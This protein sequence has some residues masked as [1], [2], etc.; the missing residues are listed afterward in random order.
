MADTETLL[1][2]LPCPMAWLEPNGQLLGCNPAFT[3]L[4]TDA[5]RFFGSGI[6]SH[7]LEKCQSSHFWREALPG[8]GLV[9]VYVSHL[10]D[11]TAVLFYMQP[12]VD[13]HGSVLD[14]LAHP[15]FIQ[16]PDGSLLASNN[17]FAAF[18]DSER[19][20]LVGLTP[21]QLFEQQWHQ[22]LDQGREQLL[23]T[24]QL[25]PLKVSDPQG[26]LWWVQ[27]RLVLQQEQPLAIISEMWDITRQLQMEAELSGGQQ[28]KLTDQLSRE[29]FLAQLDDQI[30][31][32]NRIKMMLGLMLLDLKNFQQI[33]DDFGHQIGNALLKAVAQRIRQT[34]RETDIL[35]R[36]EGD[37]F[38]IMAVHLSSSEA[39]A[40]VHHK[41]ALAFET[42]FELDGKPV[43]LSFRAGVAIYPDDAQNSDAL[44]N[45]A[46]LTLHQLKKDGGDVRFYD[47]RIDA[48]V[49]LTRELGKDL[50][51]AAERGEFFLRYQPIV[52]AY[53]NKLLGVETLVRWQHPGHGTL[54]PQEFVYIAEHVGLISELGEHVLN[55]LITDLHRWL[56]YGIYNLCLTV[57]ISP[58]QLKSPA[59]FKQTQ[60]L[61]QQL[62]GTDQFSLELELNEAAIHNDGQRYAQQL[63]E[64]KKLGVRL[65]IDEFGSINGALNNLTKLPIDTIKIDRHFIAK[66]GHESDAETLVK[67]IIRL[68]KDLGIRTSAVG[69]EEL[70]QLN[71]L[72]NERCDQ[73]QGFAVSEPMSSDDFI[74]WYHNFN[75][76]RGG[77]QP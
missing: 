76:V 54:V 36:Q 50:R 31:V 46:E 24:G 26:K 19:A 62:G 45:N 70:D 4:V 30:H 15:I 75:L 20:N 34:L 17:S 64:L 35:A 72:R 74:T 73:V 43:P 2:H 25:E 51:G 69:V 14:L 16:C 13:L 44:F 8:K 27:K 22:Q 55:L 61:L 29:E 6:G 32:A 10:P 37:R 28:P 71:F 53:G 9:R 33:N 63:H 59:L 3:D 38:A 56:D 23:S 12:A 48:M 39:M 21:S 40:Q 5:K 66:L 41:L 18:M 65:S 42:P 1:E 77:I 47:E 67:A 7:W 49:R 11:S 68:G 57:N 52:S 60:L 58:Q